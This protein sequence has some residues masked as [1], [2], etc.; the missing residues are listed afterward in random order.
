MSLSTLGFF[1][2]H[3]TCRIAKPDV[4]LSGRV[5]LVTG[6]NQGFGLIF[7]LVS[8]SLISFVF[9]SL[10]YATVLHFARMNASRI[11]IACRQVKKGE[12]AAAKVFKTCPSYRGKIDVMHLDL[13]SFDSVK[14]FAEKIDADPGRLDI[15]VLNAGV[16]RYDW[17]VTADG[18][19]ES[20]QVNYLST[21]LLA[22]LLLPK[23]EKSKAI[24]LETS[25]PVSKR[26]SQKPHLVILSSDGERFARKMTV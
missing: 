7:C 21:G 15:A 25:P 16:A 24:P 23:L 19:E 9:P 4:D 11:I 3:F 26:G 10:G 17:K 22:V 6:A 14:A 18:W 2:T 1:W 20:L 8:F 5:C 12:E 13:S